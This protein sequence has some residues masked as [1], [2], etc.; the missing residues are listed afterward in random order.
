MGRIDIGDI[1]R[2][3]L[4]PKGSGLDGSFEPLKRNATKQ[5]HNA[6]TFHLGLSSLIIPRQLTFSCLFRQLILPLS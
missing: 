2:Q 4:L 6:S 3:Y 5:I 1:V